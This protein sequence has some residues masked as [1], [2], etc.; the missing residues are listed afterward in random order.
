[1]KCSG[2]KR[3]FVLLFFCLIFCEWAAPQFLDDFCRP[4]FAV[5]SKTPDGWEFFTGDGSATMDFVLEDGFAS[6]LVDATKDRRNIWWAL[7]K[8]CVSSDM[9]LS[10]L[11]EP[12]FEFRIEARIRISH[13]PRR[14]NLHLNTQRTTDFHSHLMEYDIPDTTNW[15]TISMTT[16]GF[17]AKPG[18]KI[19]GQ[20]ALMDW[21]LGKYRV[22]VDYVK[23][24]IV[25]VASA[26]PDKGVPVPYHPPIPDPASF[27]HKIKVT[28]DSIID[29]RYPEM[30]FNDWHAEERGEKID[31]LT[32]SGTQ[33]MILR[34]DMSAF[35]DMKVSGGGLLELAT[36]SVQRNSGD[37]KDFGMIRVSEILG[38]DPGWDQGTV[39]LRNLCQQKPIDHVINTQMIV[40]TE[41][42][43]A[44][45]GKTLITISQPVLQR[46]VNGRTLGLAVQPLGAIN[47]S[48]YAMEYRDS[49]FSARLYFDTD[50]R[51]D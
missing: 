28:Q 22:D 41:V 34:W 13:A 42:N 12:G 3:L 49:E 9:D 43:G 39:T 50:K 11:D 14:I 33:V 44:Q 46:L 35:V 18:D 21:G 4:S 38:G 24:D 15:H 16:R 37:V 31:L 19:F 25:E 23:V 48:F 36:Y 20:M 32:V 6:I 7:V 47:A 45:S 2:V 29:T 40:D 5:A 26:G 10:R 51:P 17:D 30:N 27:A 8:K 1:M